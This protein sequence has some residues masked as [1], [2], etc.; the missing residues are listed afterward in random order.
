MKYLQYDFQI[1][2][3]DT[4]RVDLDS[5]ANV[6]LLDPQNFQSY[7]QGQ[8]HNYFGGLVKQSPYYIK[9]P[10]SG[11]WHLVIDLGG[12]AGKIAATVSIV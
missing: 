10:R 8:K 7:R 3:K 6:R 11:H 12:Y 9:P 5:Q 4:I 1:T 2:P